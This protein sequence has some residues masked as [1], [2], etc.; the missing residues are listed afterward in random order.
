MNRP[1]TRNWY[2]DDEP[3]IVREIHQTER[4]TFT[5]RYDHEGNELHRQ[6]EPIGFDPHRWDTSP[7]NRPKTKSARK[8]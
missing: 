5:G 8:G 4:D 1:K 3:L 2:S 6:R 7:R